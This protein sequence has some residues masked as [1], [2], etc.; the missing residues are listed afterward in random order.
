MAILKKEK[1]D[2]KDDKEDYKWENKKIEEKLEICKKVETHLKEESKMYNP[3]I[4]K[5]KNEKDIMENQLTDRESIIK[6][7]EKDIN[8]LWNKNKHLEN[9]W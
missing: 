5:H 1:A 3:K 8:D 9:F 4:E 7:W 6:E 2:L